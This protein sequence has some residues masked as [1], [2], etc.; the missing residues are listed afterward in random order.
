MVMDKKYLFS[1]IVTTTQKLDKISIGEIKKDLRSNIKHA[2]HTYCAAVT[3]CYSA[4]VLSLSVVC[5]VKKGA[6]KA[7]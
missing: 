2:S 6:N 7:D 1:P 4:L 3:Y 5:L